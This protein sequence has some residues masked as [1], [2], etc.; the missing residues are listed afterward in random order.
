MIRKILLTAT[1]CSLASSNAQTAGQF[2]YKSDEFKGTIQSTVIHNINTPNQESVNQTPRGISCYSRTDYSILG[3][4]F[5]N[6]DKTKGLALGINIAGRVNSS[7]S[8]IYSDIPQDAELILL[9]DGKSIKLNAYD[10]G[11]SKENYSCTSKDFM[12]NYVYTKYNG[13]ANFDVTFDI[14]EFADANSVQ[15]RLYSKTSNYTG[16][17]P[18]NV[19][20]NLKKLWQE[21]LTMRIK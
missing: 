10:G 6:E 21:D 13:F 3:G 2:I 5:I 7:M 18:K 17:I 16:V 20:Q 4:N 9:I 1:L 14:D 15:Y 8:G 11:S 12:N 19:R